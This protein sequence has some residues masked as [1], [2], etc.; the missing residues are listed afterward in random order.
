MRATANLQRAKEHK[1]VLQKIVHE[2]DAIPQ[3]P[4]T[5]TPMLDAVVLPCFDA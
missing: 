3:Q 1:L 5:M 4:E 2:L